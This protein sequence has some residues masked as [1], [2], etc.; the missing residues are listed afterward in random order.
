MTGA[1]SRDRELDQLAGDGSPVPEGDPSAGGAHVLDPVA[2]LTEHRHQVPL[3]VQVGHAQREAGHAVPSG[4]R[5]PRGS[6]SA[7]APARGRIRPPTAATKRRAVASPR[8][9][10]YMARRPSRDHGQLAHRVL[11][12]WPAAVTRSSAVL[13]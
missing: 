5:S 12:P 7:S 8:P 11:R 10:A 9:P 4:V 1:R 13:K 3:A 6:P 2:L